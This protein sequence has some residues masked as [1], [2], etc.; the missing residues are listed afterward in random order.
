VINS[1]PGPISH[2][3][4]NT[5][6]YSLKLSIVNYAHSTGNRD[7]IIIT[8]GNRQ[9]PIRWHYRR[10]PC[11]LPFSH[12]TAWLAYHSALCFSKVIWGQ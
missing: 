6:T 5:A 2:H 9:R 11:D 3:F 10:P 4:R 7:R 12:N 8:V 1:D